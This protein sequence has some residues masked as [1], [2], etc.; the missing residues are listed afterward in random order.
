MKYKAHKKMNK[1]IDCLSMFVFSQDLVL[2]FESKLQLLG[3]NGV[4]EREW[5]FDSLIKYVKPLSGPPRR[6]SLI[7]GCQDGNVYKVFID[8]GFPIPV[9]KQTTPI[10]VADISADRQKLAVIDDFRSLFVY[11]IKTQ[12]LLFQERNVSSIAWNLEVEDMLAYTGEDQLYIKCRDLPPQQ[13]R[14]PG[15]VVGFK[16]SK[17]FCLNENNMN[18]IDVPQST[19]FYRFLEMKDFAMSYK[20]ACLGVTEQDWRALGIEALQQRDFKFA[21]KAFCRIRDIKFIDL[22]VNAEQMAEMNNLDD[23]WMK[24]EIL[25]LQGKH[26]EAANYLIKNNLVDKAATLMISMKKFNEANELMKKHGKSKSGEGAALDPSILIKQ[27]EFERDSGN[28][29]EAATLYVQANRH[30]EAIDIYGKRQNLDQ[31][32]EICKNLDKL[33]HKN[34][35]ELCAKYFRQAGHHTY[36][37][38]AYLRLG[39]LK[40]LMNLHVELHKW[41]EAKMLAK[42]NPEMQNIIWLPYADWLSANDEFFK[43]QEAY[44]KAGRPD[45]SL[46]IIEFLTNNAVIERRFQD[47]A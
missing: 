38:Q 21:K 11:D 3:F 15:L 22:T 2:C 8:N 43:A 36:A 24:G 32:M 4:L 45:L 35:I 5:V 42:Q 6:E 34:E 41:D 46:R 26:K 47:A 28:W 10:L 12:A 25:A 44:K 1:K 20:L 40:A 33:N 14:L 31:I 18:I 19:T 30:K 9:I 13:Q 27:A 7:V 39:D 16:G 23:L 37:K 29:K 17:I